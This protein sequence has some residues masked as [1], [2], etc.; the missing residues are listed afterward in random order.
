MK[1]EKRARAASK[2]DNGEEEGREAKEGIEENDERET[3]ARTSGGW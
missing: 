1:R 2:E 3:D